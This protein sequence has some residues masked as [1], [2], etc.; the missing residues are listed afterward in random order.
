MNTTTWIMLGYA[1]PAVLGTIISQIVIWSCVGDYYSYEWNRH[2]ALKSVRRARQ[3]RKYFWAWPA[4]AI[5]LGVRYVPR[6]VKTVLSNF[7]AWRRRYA[8]KYQHVLEEA[9]AEH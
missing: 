5:Y 2:D 1:A 8:E 9:D 6:G 7:F 3:L 4:V